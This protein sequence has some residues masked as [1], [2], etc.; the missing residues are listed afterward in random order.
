M[1]NNLEKYDYWLQSAK[2]DLDTAE[3]MFKSKRYVYVAFTCQQAIEK[4]VKA[5]H[6]LYTGNEAPK[7]HNI[8]YIFELIFNNKDYSSKITAIDFEE[9]RKKYISLFTKL[10]S[11][12]ISERYTDY[13][14]KIGESLNEENSYKLLK[15]TQEAFIW[16]TSL[17]TFWK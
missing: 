13:K 10:H 16:L 7:S 3:Y 1:L 4:L 9:K 6:V 15:E 5:L 8:L 17:K 12:Y 14:R 11:Y 2:Y